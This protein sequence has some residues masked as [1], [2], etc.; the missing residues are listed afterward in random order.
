MAD[1]TSIKLK[2]SPGILLILFKRANI[3]FNFSH[4]NHP[5]STTPLH[6]K[7]RQMDRLLAAFAAIGEQKLALD[8]RLAEHRAQVPSGVATELEVALL[9]SVYQE[10]Y[11]KYMALLEQGAVL[12]AVLFISSSQTNTMKPH[13][14]FQHQQKSQQ[15]Y[16]LTELPTS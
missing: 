6:Y 7:I 11:R 15:L 14:P 1:S 13:P 16:G 2:D 4:I 5:I 9:E 3:L 12:G 8:N 10:I